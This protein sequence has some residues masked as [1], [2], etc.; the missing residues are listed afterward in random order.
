MKNK[1]VAAGLAFFLGSFGIHKFYL[2]DTGSG[3][4][5][6][7]LSIL[8]IRLF[9]MPVSGI[10]GLIDGIM[11]LSMSDAAFDKKYNSGQDAQSRQRQRGRGQYRQRS[12][13]NQPRRSETRRTYQPKGAPRA[14]APPRKRKKV[15]RDNPFKRSGVKKYKDFDL[16]EAIIDFKKGLELEPNDI[17]LHFNLACAYSLT[18]KPKNAYYHLSKAVSFGFKDFEKIKTHDDLAFLRIHDEFHE[19]Q[20]NGYRIIKSIPVQDAEEKEEEIVKA[21]PEVVNEDNALNDDILLS[22]LNKLDELRKK[23]LISD[24]EFHTEKRKLLRD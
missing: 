24:K 4:F 23:G 2:K 15:V 19:F 16:E 14:S 3:I 10:L 5:Y 20:N 22:Q 12:Y 11:L 8:G 9:A 17:S 21:K 6:L 18:E 13:P 7:I 1:L